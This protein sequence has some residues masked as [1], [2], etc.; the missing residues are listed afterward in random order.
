MRSFIIHMQGDAR[1]APNARKLQS[2]LPCAEIV[3]AVVGRDI[4]ETE[5]HR[6]HPGDLHRPHYPFPIR[7]AE[8]GVF[9]SHRRCWQ[10]IIDEGLDFALIVED[11][12]AI[13]PDR[14]GVA[15]EL[16]AAHATP[17]MYVRLPVKQRE[18]PVQVLAAA[19]GM[20]L[21]L[22]RVIG[23]QCICQVVGRD[24]AARLLALGSDIDRPVDTLIQ[25]HWVTGQPVHALLGSGN[26]EIAHELGGSTIQTKPPLL[27]RPQREVLRAIY[28]AQVA[29]RPQRAQ[30]AG[31]F[32]S[33]R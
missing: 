22:P 18:S 33:R 13:D 19:G 23:L 24:A 4:V 28:R 26:R 8:L 11:D 20:Q 10:R 32:V 29:L 30:A 3:E 5:H 17:G 9:E 16:V 21:V 7:P 14:F 25:M 2:L 15:L 31:S 1:R 27:S 6:I 12:L